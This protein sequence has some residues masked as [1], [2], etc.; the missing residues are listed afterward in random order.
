VVE[1]RLRDASGLWSRRKTCA[2]TEHEH[3]ERA[4]VAY[5][6]AGAH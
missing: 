1:P 3:L 6:V 5:P 2:E 4:R